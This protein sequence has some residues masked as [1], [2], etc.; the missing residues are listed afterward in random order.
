MP[1]D[2]GLVPDVPGGYIARSQEALQR[3]GGKT[4]VTLNPLWSNERWALAGVEEFPDIDAVYKH[5]E[6]LF[7]QDHYRF[8][9]GFSILGV[10]W[11][12]DDTSQ[13]LRSTM[14]NSVFKVW[15]MRLPEA[16]YTLSQ[17]ERNANSARAAQILE[18]VEGKQIIV[19]AC[20]WSNEQWVLFGVE[21]FP[22]VEA[23]Q[24]HADLLFANDHFRYSDGV[25][26]LGTSWRIE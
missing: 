6:I 19:C 11:P 12:R 23:A 15:M 9:E 13:T 16:W 14:E 7:F 18:Q 20:G 21:E 25:S 8:T 5:A 2:R 10:R 3:V 26:M 24:R 22:S 17:E 1:A 4:I